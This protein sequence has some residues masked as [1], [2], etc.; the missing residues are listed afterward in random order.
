MKKLILTL[1]CLIILC[2]CGNKQEVVKEVVIENKESSSELNNVYYYYQLTDIQKSYYDL[3]LEASENNENSISGD[4]KFD[5]DDFF[6][7][8]KAFSY[9]YPNYYWWGKGVS[10]KYT[11]NSFTSKC[12]EDVDTIKANLELLDSKVNSILNECINENNYLTIKNI[13]DYIV[14]NVKYDDSSNNSHNIVGS[15]LEGK[16]VCDGYAFAFKYLVNKAGF[17]CNIIEGTAFNTK[18]EIEEHAWNEIELNGNWYLVDATWDNSIDIN[19][20]NESISYHY[21]LIDEEMM[22]SD[23]YPNETYRFHDCNDKS[24]FYVNMPGAYFAEYNEEDISKHMD[25]WL[26]Q[27]FK[28]FYLK[29]SNF[30]DG[31]KAHSYLLENGEFV[32]IFQKVYS[33][34]DIEI[35]G[36]YGSNNHILHIYYI[37][38]NSSN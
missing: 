11:S 23:H 38:L 32:N 6:I 29:F 35:G 9:D 24:L 19:T 30:D 28:D 22:N 34:Y 4:I 13:H 33:N 7:A 5:R 10:S 31:I 2:G 36:D 15:L 18:N 20:G 27:G 1:I 37:E 17:N 26:R 25:T 14:S 12:D 3:L 16:S 21:F 8:L